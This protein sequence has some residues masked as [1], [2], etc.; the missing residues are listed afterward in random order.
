MSLDGMWSWDDRAYWYIRTVGVDVWWFAEAKDGSWAY[1]FKG[2]QQ[3][4]AITGEY[5]DVP[6]GRRTTHGGLSANVLS[7]TQLS[8]QDQNDPSGFA[9]VTRVVPD[10]IEGMHL[11]PSP[12]TC[13]AG[14][15][16]K[17]AVTGVWLADDCGKYYIRQIG[18]VVWW[19][20]EHQFGAWCNVFRGTR[21]S[22]NVVGQW[23]DVPK[24]SSN[25]EGRLELACVDEMMKQTEGPG[26]F[27]GTY[28]TKVSAMKA[29]LCLTQLSIEA[30]DE[31]TVVGVRRLTDEPYLWP[32]Y[33]TVDGLPVDASQ[34]TVTSNAFLHLYDPIPRDNDGRSNF[35]AVHVH[36]KVAIPA[37]IGQFETCLTTMRWR[38]R[39]A[40]RASTILGVFVVAL[41]EDQSAQSSILS[42]RGAFRVALNQCL[43]EAIGHSRGAGMRA[44]KSYLH[45][46]VVK[47]LAAGTQA[48][49]HT[50]HPIVND[51]D[52]IGSGVKLFSFDELDRTGQLP[53]T[54]KCGSG[55]NARYEIFGFAEKTE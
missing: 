43:Q 13:L 10:A 52:L 14:F 9:V 50:A 34:S 3:G 47:A 8:I 16:E 29:R 25:G 4:L 24:C 46:A 19:V 12:H 40:A 32:F 2:L 42:V 49:D 39:S 45:A 37:S 5:V 15:D 54:L 27:G 36:D 48:L 23:A 44:M 11:P 20:G 26:G 28:W 6:K 17:R 33:F 38:V 31:Q 55:Y 30:Q 41:E 35:P 21:Q 7:K 18:D 51:D 1:V 53:F 22:R